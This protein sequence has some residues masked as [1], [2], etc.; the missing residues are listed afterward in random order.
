MLKLATNPTFSASVE[1]PLPD[2]KVA[3]VECEFRYIPTTKLA[4]FLREAAA[5]SGPGPLWHRLLAWI[6]KRVPWVSRFVKPRRSDADYLSDIVTKWSGVDME[7]SHESAQIL[8]E[9]YPHAAALIV[10]TWATELS[11]LRLGN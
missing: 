1:I 5:N 6:A 2:G 3:K 11:K 4:A 8:C 7:F 9:M 10:K